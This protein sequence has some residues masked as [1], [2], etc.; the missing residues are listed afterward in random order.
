MFRFSSEQG[1]SDYSDLYDWSIRNREGFWTALN[2]F[3]DVKF[4]VEANA[5]LVQE[6]DMTSATWFPGGELNFAAHLLRH[7][8]H[9]IILSLKR[10]ISIFMNLDR[11]GGNSQSGQVVC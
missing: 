10:L 9:V 8:L 3:C 5:V 6:G 4:S 11:T 2:R 1:F 7:V